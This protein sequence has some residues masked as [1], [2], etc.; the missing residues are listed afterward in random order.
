MIFIFFLNI[1]ILHDYWLTI[2]PYF[3]LKKLVDIIPSK[4]KLFDT[5]FRKKKKILILFNQTV[6]NRKDEQ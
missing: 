6:R 5:L 2:I 3:S 1:D 4:Q